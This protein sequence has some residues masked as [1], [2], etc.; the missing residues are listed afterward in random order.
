MRTLI[1][2][3]LLMLAAAPA[4]CGRMTISPSQFSPNDD[5]V[6]DELE[7]LLDATPGEF[8]TVRIH[9]PAGA[10][11]V[12][13]AENFPLDLARTE[14]TWDGL[15]VTG[16]APNG[17]YTIKASFRGTQASQVTAKAVLDN[18]HKWP[19]LKYTARP[20][21]P[22]GVWFEGNP[23]W[24]GYPQDKSGAKQY[25]DRCFADLRN[26]GFNTVTV[27]NCPE[28]LWETLLQ[29]AQRN[30]IKVVLEVAPLADL[31]SDKPVTESRV[32]VAAK[33]VYGKIGKYSSLI[34][35]QIRDEPAPALVPNWLLVQRVLAAVDPT[36]PAFSCFNSGASLATVADATRLS[37]AVFDIYPIGAGAPPQTLGGFVASLDA[38]NEAARGNALWPVLQA[39]AKPSA[40]RYPTPEELRAMTYLSL[41]EGAKGVFYFI[42]QS[43]PDHPEKLEGLVEADG[44]ARLLP[45]Q[46]QQELRPPLYAA[47][48]TL[49]GELRQ[50]SGVLMYLKPAAARS[51]SK[52]DVRSRSFIDPAGRPVL[53]VA[54]TRPDAPVT[55]QFKVESDAAWRDELTGESLAPKDLVLEVSLAP[56]AGRVLVRRGGE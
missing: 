21:F 2:T 41:A 12:T 43:M 36:R 6:R 3:I 18:S 55:A 22:I 31:V 52:M 40:W 14:L 33:R 24:G 10:V 5:G 53:I 26:H 32:Y 30:G 7:I 1:P 50:L 17:T 48:S 19:P 11:V 13:L 38:F 8:V 42:Y 15:G 56:G 25:Y 35:Y 39:F 23:A 37:E 27:P 34:R 4:S 46:A 9:N 20:Y 45:S 54:S 51:P 28:S 29:S 44:R 16:V 49:A 47:A